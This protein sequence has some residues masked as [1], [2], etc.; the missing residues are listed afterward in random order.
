MVFTFPHWFMSV[1]AAP[2]F[3]WLSQVLLSQVILTH[4]KL[5]HRHTR[6]RYL[7]FMHPLPSD[8]LPLMNFH[9][10]LFGCPLYTFLCVLSY[11]YEYLK[12][13]WLKYCTNLLTCTFQVLVTV[14]IFHTFPVKWK[15]CISCIGDFKCV[16]FLVNWRMKCFLMGLE[17]SPTS[18]AKSAI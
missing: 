8:I 17:N 7:W 6:P 15:P 14:Q 2:T 9:T 4:S 3:L 5:R 1:R 13:H 12:V 16:I 18:S 11:F 10:H